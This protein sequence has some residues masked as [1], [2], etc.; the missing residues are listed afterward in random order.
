MTSIADG[1]LAN[2]SGKIEILGKRPFFDGPYSNI[3]RGKYDGQMVAVK[4]LKPVGRIHAMRRKIHR[5]R[6]VWGALDHPNIL[7]CI[8]YAE[9]DEQFEPFGALISPVSV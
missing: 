5:E 2:I 6:A 8:G 3:Y 7:P 4:V 9:D 1:E